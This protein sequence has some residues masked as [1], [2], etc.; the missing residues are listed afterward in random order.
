MKLPVSEI[1]GAQEV[2]A[3]VGTMGL[4]WSSVRPVAALL[5]G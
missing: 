5:Q 3:W 2:P 4:A 1:E